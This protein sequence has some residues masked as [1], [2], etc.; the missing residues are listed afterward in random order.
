[1]TGAP[2]ARN[3]PLLGEAQ[4]LQPRLH[5]AVQLVHPRL[6][7]RPRRGPA[8]PRLRC[9]RSGAP[10]AAAI[11]CTVALL[12]LLHLLLLP[13]RSAGAGPVFADQRCVCICPRLARHSAPQAGPAAVGVAPRRLGWR[14][15]AVAIPVPRVCVVIVALIRTAS[16]IAPPGPPPPW[17]LFLLLLSIALLCVAAGTMRR[18]QRCARPVRGVGGAARAALTCRGGGLR[19][20]VVVMRCIGAA[21]SAPLGARPGAIIMASPPPFLLALAPSSVALSVVVVVAAA[22]MLSGVSRCAPPPAC[23]STCRL[24]LL[25]LRLGPP[26]RSARIS[27]IFFELIV[28]SAAAPSVMLRLLCCVCRVCY[29]AV[30]E[31]PPPAVVSRAAAPVRLGDPAAT[32][33]PPSGAPAPGCCLGSCRRSDAL[34]D[35]RCRGSRRSTGPRLLQP[36]LL[37]R[38]VARGRKHAPRERAV[39]GQRRRARGRRHHARDPRE[40]QQEGS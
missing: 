39:A 1:M 35:S 4:R 25:A 30:S 29:R 31:R 8:R 32:A 27:V 22:A 40:A 12:L 23:G 37:R 21:A 24:L 26:V 14:L 9:L 20:S 28:E 34:H 36:Y 19:R 38:D 10:P 5:A 2:L 6:L 18:L 15:A 33:L 13:G 3:S 11:A 17:R 16:P 7:L